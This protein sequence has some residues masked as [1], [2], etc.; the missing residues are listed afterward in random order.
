[1]LVSQDECSGGEN[2][3]GRSSVYAFTQY[4]W[5]AVVLRKESRT[6]GCR[7]S[8]SMRSNEETIASEV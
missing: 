7:L 5:V 6:Q 3:F 1:M 2:R 8:L 4:V